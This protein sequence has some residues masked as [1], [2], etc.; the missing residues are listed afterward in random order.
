MYK[1]L[2]IFMMLMVSLSVY[3]QGT[4]ATSVYGV[5]KG[6]VRSTT[7][8]GGNVT[9][10]EVLFTLS[11]GNGGDAVKLTLSGYG[12]GQ[13]DLEDIHIPHVT[14]KRGRHGWALHGQPTTTVTVESKNKGR[15]TFSLQIIWGVDKEIVNGKLDIYWT[16]YYEG[17]LINFDFKGNRDVSTGI[18]HV[19][20]PFS[21]GQK[22]EEN[23]IFDLNGRRVSTP[24]KGIY[25]INGKKVLV[26]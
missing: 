11:E 12:I 4:D 9:T 18:N 5:Y 13:Y 23:K 2:F 16:L 17:K 10:R 1:K 24:Q 3:A 25:I 26:K 6:K 21:E 7:I 15:V 8:G 22:V 20:S 14:L 19:V